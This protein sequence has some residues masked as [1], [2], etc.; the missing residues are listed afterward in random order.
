MIITA[1]RYRKLVTGP[2]YSHQAVE[3][4]AAIGKYDVPEDILL[5][6]SSWVRAQVEGKSPVLADPVM[7]REEV[8]QLYRQRDQLRGAVAQAD[9]ELKAVRDQINANR[10]KPEDDDDIPF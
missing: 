5:E 6:L 8:A 2:G 1:V 10:K 3:A 7:L 9:L 4:E